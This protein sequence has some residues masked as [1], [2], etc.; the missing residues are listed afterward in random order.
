MLAMKIKQL[1]SGLSLIE[2]MVGLGVGMIV[3]AGVTSVYVSSVISSSDTLKQSKLNQELTT[4]M[5]VMSNDIMRAG[6]WTITDLE[7][8]N[9]PQNNPFSQADNTV[10][11]VVESVAS[12]T[13]QTAVNDASGGECILYTYDADLDGVLDDGDVRGFRLNNG[14]VEMREQG[15]VTNNTRHDN[16]ND[17]DD[18]WIP[19]TD[20]RVINITNLDFIL[21]GSECVNT[22]EP[23]DA[24]EDGDGTNDNA[25]EMDCYAQAPTNGSGDVTVETRQVDIAINGELVGDTSVSAVM[26]Q[27]VRVRNDWVRVR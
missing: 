25:A 11:E 21:T 1:Q 3:V 20:S 4:L 13:T 18:S 17:A 8:Y 9:R 5:S 6:V 19:L 7:D 12:N 16:C 2:L 24:D 22:R 15:D 14:V 10:L 23:N 26:N 27:T